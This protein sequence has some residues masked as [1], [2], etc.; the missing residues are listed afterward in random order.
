MTTVDDVVDKFV[1]FI[2]CSEHRWNSLTEYADFW[3]ETRDGA[4]QETAADYAL[5]LIVLMLTADRL[6]KSPGEFGD[7]AAGITRLVEFSGGSDSTE[8]PGC[9]D[10]DFWNWR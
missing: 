5:F 2:A 6:Q 1:L 10:R 7:K 9:L 4:I 8:V 3:M